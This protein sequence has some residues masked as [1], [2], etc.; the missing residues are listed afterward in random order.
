MAIKNF[1][2]FVESGVIKKQA[3]DKYRVKDLVEESNRKNN[4][5]KEILEKVGL[6]DEN[7]NDIIESC[8][9]ILM[10]LIR[11]KLY[12]DGYSASGLSAHEA[13]VSYLKKL[14]FSDEDIE[15]MNQLRYFRNGMM[16]YGKRFDREY[17]EKVIYF[18]NKIRPR[19]KRLAK[20]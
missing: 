10:Y 2:E 9:D 6:K 13:E 3:A 12:L 8:Y 15:F 11:A 7:A 1:E 14:G 18:L 5:L 17:A 4:S 16:Y 19:L 20:A